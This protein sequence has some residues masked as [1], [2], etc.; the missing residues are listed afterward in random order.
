M[1]SKNQDA[2]YKRSFCMYVLEPIYM[3]FDAIMNFKKEMVTKLL[4]KLTTAGGKLVVDVLKT[5]EKELEGKPLMKA[6][7]RNWLPAGDA[8]FQ[9]IVIH[10]P[11]P[12]TAQ[13]YRAELLY[14]GP[15]DDPACMGI[16]NCDP[17]APRTEAQLCISGQ[18]LERASG[19]QSSGTWRHQLG[20]SSL[21]SVFRTSTTRFP[22][23]VVSFPNSL[24]TIS[25]LK[26]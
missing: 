21:S 15:H 8:M 14:E 20:A 1:W 10:L 4:G 11:S 17:E 12:V 13:K 6:V 2:D 5:E 25:F 3:V 26:F 7:M 9:M 22:P 19:S 18:L 23:A 16:K 24:V